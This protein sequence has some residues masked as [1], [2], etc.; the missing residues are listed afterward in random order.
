ML[1]HKSQVERHGSPFA[2]AAAR[3]SDKVQYGRWVGQV[4]RFERLPEGPPNDGLPPLELINREKY[5]VPEEH[6][7][8]PFKAVPA[9]EVL[10]VAVFASGVPEQVAVRVCARF[11]NESSGKV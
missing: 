4:R 7:K 2:P 10:E 9:N 3:V 5:P 6:G 8:R 1:A 11:I